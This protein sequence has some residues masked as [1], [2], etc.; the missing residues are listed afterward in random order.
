[1]AFFTTMSAIEVITGTFTH[2]CKSTCSW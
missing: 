1:M 2:L